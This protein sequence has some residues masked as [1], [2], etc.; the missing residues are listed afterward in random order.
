[1]FLRWALVGLE[2]AGEHKNTKRAKSKDKAPEGTKAKTN[3][4]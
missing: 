1:M 4:K 2:L 3:K